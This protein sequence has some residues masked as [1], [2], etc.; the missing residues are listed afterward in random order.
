MTATMLLV[1]LGRI[2]AVA[3]F[4][5]FSAADK[6]LAFTKARAQCETLVP[7]ARLASLFILAGLAI[8]VCCPLAIITGIGDRLGAF[9]LAGYCMATAVMFKQFWAK[10]DFWPDHDG[11]G[12][13]A[14]WDFLKNI[15]L[16]AALLTFT[17]GTDGGQL[18]AFVAHP[19]ASSHPYGAVR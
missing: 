11:A 8:E 4:L 5:P 16:G 14:F 13:Q 1:A 6:A 18:A 17:I 2:G 19:L 15:A 10:G 3:L 12:R 9:V 7:N